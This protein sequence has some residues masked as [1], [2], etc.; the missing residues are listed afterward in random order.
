VSV[1]TFCLPQ[2]S[3]CVPDAASVLTFAVLQM[4][5]Y[6]ERAFAFDLISLGVAS[7]KRKKRK[8]PTLSSLFPL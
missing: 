4:R 3:R 1:N 8:S 7:G 5:K 2:T 6:P